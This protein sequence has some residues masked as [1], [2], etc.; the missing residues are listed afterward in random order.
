M[1]EIDSHAFPLPISAD[2]QQ[3]RELGIKKASMS[4]VQYDHESYLVITCC[5]KKDFP[6][7]LMEENNTST[8]FQNALEHARTINTNKTVIKS[9]KQCHLQELIL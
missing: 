9:D 1:S 6:S 4:K 5:D 3:T 7:E 2:Q 8:F